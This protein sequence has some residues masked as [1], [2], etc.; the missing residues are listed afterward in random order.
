MLADGLYNQ[1][2]GFCKNHKLQFIAHTNGTQQIVI[3]PG[4]VTDRGG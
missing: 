1:F 4:P 2:G 3:F